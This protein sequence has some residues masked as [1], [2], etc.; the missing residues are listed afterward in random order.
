MKLWKNII[1]SAA[2]LALPAL[3]SAE[4]VAPTGTDYWEVQQ[5]SSKYA[6]GIDTLDEALLQSV[7]AKDAIAHWEIVTEGPIKLNDKVQGFDKIYGWLTSHLGHRKGYEGFPWHF[8]TN[9]IV[10]INGSDAN[11]RFYMH[12]RPGIAGG[13]YY[14]KARKTPDGWRVVDLHLE[15]QIWNAGGYSGQPAKK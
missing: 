8:V 10:E 14:M 3:A 12:N 15:E 13:V 11:L 5:L 6:W 1:V 2:L 7:F 9:Q 4:Q